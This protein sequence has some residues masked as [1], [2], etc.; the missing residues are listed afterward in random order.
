MIVRNRLIV[1]LVRVAIFTLYVVSLTRFLP[2]YASFWVAMSSFS[3]QMGIVGTVMV[4]LEIIYTVIDLIRHGL[5]GAAAGPHMR[6]ALPITVFCVLA[7]IFHF[8]SAA[9]CN[10]APTNSFSTFF[11]VVLIL[12]PLVD[13]IALDE[14]GTVRFSGALTCQL[15]P[16]LYFVFG[17]LRTLIW[18]DVYV[19][20]GH[21]YALPFL[22]YSEPYI[23]GY[24]VAFFAITLGSNILAVFVNNVLAGKYGFIRERLD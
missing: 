10:A 3:V 6:L 18:P 19:W 13:W 4:G 14:K 16:I 8:T 5:H 22:D 1:L 2:E 9:P 21:L 12:G 24:A 17:Y 7:G 23:V 15:Y 20:G 11:H